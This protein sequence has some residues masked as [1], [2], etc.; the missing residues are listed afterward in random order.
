MELYG[1]KSKSIP[2]KM[3]IHV[4]EIFFLFLSYW[5]VFGS[6]ADFLHNTFGI[7][8]A[9]DAAGR[10]LIIF[11][12]NIV[13]FMRLA[14]TMLYLLQRKI[15]WEESISIP[16]AFALYYVGYSIFVLPVNNSIDWLDYVAIVIFIIGCMLNTGG[17]LLRHIWK[18][19][20]ANKGKIYTGGFFAYSMHINYFGDLLWVTGYALVTRN[21]YSVVI[22]G[23]LL[24]FFVW[25][26]IPKLD[27]Y[28]HEKYGKDFEQYAKRTKKLVPFIY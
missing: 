25:Y 15:P 8:D 23:F 21:W 17:E 5:I 12:F 3:L 27:R 6:G 20:P 13:I 19:D 18:R 4:L 28:L 24:S 16:V 26:N 2:Q 9:G 7:H 11:V 1:E 14:F 10:R 22:P